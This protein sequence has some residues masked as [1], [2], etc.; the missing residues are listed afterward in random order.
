MS[1]KISDDMPEIYG[2]KSRIEQVIMNVISNSI[3][4]TPEGGSIAVTGECKDGEVYIGVRDNGV[5]IPEA[6]IP[7]IFDRFY[8]VDKARSRETGGTGLGLSIAQEIVARHNGRIDVQSQVGEGTAVTI[9]LP[10]NG[11]GERKLDDGKT[12]EN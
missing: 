4:Y 2:D 5:G 8:R 10:V 12:P 9:I 6:D 1:L 7:R 11:A 3:K